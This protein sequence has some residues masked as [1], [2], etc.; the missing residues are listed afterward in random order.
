MVSYLA[1]SVLSFYLVLTQ[2]TKDSMLKLSMKNGEK[3]FND[4]S[5]EQSLFIQT[6]YNIAKG[7]EIQILLTIDLIIFTLCASFAIFIKIG[8]KDRKINHQ[9]LYQN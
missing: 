3:V 9:T 7:Q 2:W 8:L 6:I 5:S 1:G 4:F